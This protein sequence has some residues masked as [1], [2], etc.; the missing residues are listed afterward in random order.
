M[1]N[2][3]SLRNRS[4]T[5]SFLL[6]KKAV[7]ILLVLFCLSLLLFI[8][9]LSIGS[10]MINPIVVVQNFLGV[11]NG[12]HAFIIGTLRL[13]RMILSLLVGI[14]LGV[15]GLLL[16]GIVRNPLA[17]PDIIGI[18]GGASVAAVIF[19]TYFS[20][21]SIKWIPFVALTGAGLVSL[22]IYLLAWKKGVTPI[23][24]VL[25]GIGVQA[26]MGA[27]VTMMIVLSPTYSTS[28]AFMVFA[29]T[30]NVGCLATSNDVASD[31]RSPLLPLTV[32]MDIFVVGGFVY[33][34]VACSL[35]LMLTSV[36]L[37]RFA[38]W[39]TKIQQS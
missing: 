23:R 16:Q 2:Y 18:T 1:K 24:L 4:G 19:I 31:Q 26:G 10:T 22:I 5:I 39:A 35:L 11:G 28:E 32:K 15:S 8:I 3:R 27:L 38:C 13:P 17:S 12:E 30:F 36:Q 25:I 33:I 21:I 7:M 9:G 6:E 34:V 20:E 14:A 37:P 29:A